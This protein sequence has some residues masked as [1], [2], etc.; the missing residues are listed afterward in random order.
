ML[1]AY[2]WNPEGRADGHVHGRT[3]PGWAHR[4]VV[5]TGAAASRTG[6]QQRDLASGNVE[7]ALRRCF[8]RTEVAAM[9]TCF[10]G[11]VGF[12]CGCNPGAAAF[13]GTTAVVVVLTGDHIV[14]VNCVDSRAVL[15]RGSNIVPISFDHKV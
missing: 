2:A 8:S 13:C 10:C 1:G 12:Q 6:R 5:H 14:V 7:V 3:E 15:Y 9:H 11:S 4:P